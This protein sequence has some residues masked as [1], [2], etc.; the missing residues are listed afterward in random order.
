MITELSPIKVMYVE[1]QNGTQDASLTF[2]KLEKPLP[3]LRGRKFY[4]L[5]DP[6]KNIYYACVQLEISSDRP[7]QWGFR[8]MD[9]PG[10]KFVQN[11][12]KNWSGKEYL[13][14]ETFRKMMKENSFD[15][16]RLPIE[17]YKSQRELILY[18]PIKSS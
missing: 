7:R 13:I 8:I 4:G 14:G 12:I 3:T 2:N 16:E 11:K 6:D 9:L 1:S 15:A 17:F 18:L 5:F 10:G